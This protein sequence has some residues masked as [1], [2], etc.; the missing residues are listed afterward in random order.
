MSMNC[1]ETEKKIPYFLQ[2]ELGGSE[3]EPD[4]WRS[5]WSTWR[6]VWNAGRS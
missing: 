1:K 4:R 5:F 3:L 6:T 2:D